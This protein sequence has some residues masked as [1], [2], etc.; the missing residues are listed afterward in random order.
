MLPGNVNV[1]DFAIAPLKKVPQRCCD[2]QHWSIAASP[3]TMW[4]V[5]NIYVLPVDIT[6]LYSGTDKV[7]SAVRPSLFV[8]RW[9]GIRFKMIFVTCHVLKRA[10]GVA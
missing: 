6:R 8:V 9:L 7:H 5:D 3:S 1:I 2:R 4:Q 10:L